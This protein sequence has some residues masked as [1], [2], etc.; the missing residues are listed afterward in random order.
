MASAIIKQM[1]RTSLYILFFLLTQNLS[2]K[3]LLTAQEQLWVKTH[4]LVYYAVHPHWLPFEGLDN[5]NQHIG[6]APEY[7]RIIA[8]KTG[9]KFELLKATSRQDALDL[10]LKHEVSLISGDLLNK[11]LKQ[12]FE[13]TF[14][15][16]ESA[17]VII[18]NNRHR[19]VENLYQIRDKKIVLVDGFAYS[20]RI[21]LKYPTIRFKTVKNIEQALA[22]VSQGLY[23]A[24]L[25]STPLASY[26]IAKNSY[27]NI[28]VVGKTKLVLRLGFFIEKRNQKLKEILNKVFL[29]ISEE[30]RNT[31]MQRWVTKHYI[32]KNNLD[33]VWILSAIFAFIIFAYFI[34]NRKLRLEIEKR[35]DAESQLR[36]SSYALK[37]TKESVEYALRKARVSQEIAE[38]A[39]ENAEIAKIQAELSWEQAE[40]A[41][42]EA[43]QANQAKSDFLA[44]MSH[45]IRTPMNAV[46]GMSNLAL[47][48]NLDET[49]RNYIKKVKQAGESLLGI[50]ND[51]LD[52][53]KIEAGKLE[54]EAIEFELVEVLENVANI[55]MFKVEEHKLELLFDVHAH[56]PFYLQGDPLRLGQIL[57]NLIN[58][59]VKFTPEGEIILEIRPIRQNE[60]KITLQFSIIDTGIGMTLEQQNKLFKA[61]NQ[62]DN[63][64]TRKYG[65]TGLGL[66][67]CKKLT[68]MMEGEIWVHSHRNK[69]S[70]FQ[71]T[72]QFSHSNKPK[73]HINID[74]PSFYNKNILIIDENKTTL[75][76]LSELLHESQIQTM[77]SQSLDNAITQLKQQNKQCDL[78]MLD[79][80]VIETKGKE[81]IDTL[82]QTMK[83]KEDA[84][85]VLLTAGSELKVISLLKRQRLNIKAFLAKPF[86]AISVADCLSKTLGNK[87]E[88]VEEIIFPEEQYSQNIEQVRGRKILLV[89]DNAL[90]TELAIA[91]LEQHG[92]TVKHAEHGQDA[93]DILAT[94]EV[95]DGI[96]MDIQM[97][98]L[99]GYET[100]KAIREQPKFKDLPIIAMTA[101]VMKTDIDKA[102]RSGMNGHIGKPIDVKSLFAS[103]AEHIGC[104]IP[105]HQAP[106]E[107]VEKKRM[108]VSN[109]T[110]S[111]YG[112]N[113]EQGLRVVMGDKPL[114][115][116]I[117]QRFYQD[118]VDFI[119]QF[120]ENLAK[121]NKDA[122]RIAHTLK[123]LAGTIG[124]QSLQSRAAFLEKACKDNE[125]SEIP[126]LLKVAVEEL[127]LVLAS[128]HK[129]FQV[130]LEPEKVK[131]SNQAIDKA[132]LSELI[133]E[134]KEHLKRNSFGSLK[135]S[136]ELS[137][138]LIGNEHQE[139]IDILTNKI[140]A[141]AFAD[142]LVALSALETALDLS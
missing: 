17:L 112:V 79:W 96:L 22:G 2:A 123:G 120:N 126:L 98:V 42:K 114:Y 105:V 7:L 75:K 5:Q 119:Q 66:V 125:E 97:P 70:T 77:V 21:K 71:F 88:Q 133:S 56:S 99:D 141:F 62:A 10:A 44:N 85:F 92:I 67:I 90:N 20:E 100:T 103:M 137:D 18:M 38:M 132:Q 19:Y 136:I 80:K 32:E 12:S 26:H 46:I 87:S 81:I 13:P 52:F 82:R 29:S 111:L 36:E 1:K 84:G 51:I 110:L 86:H 68:E 94:G 93:L 106:T 49:Q 102:I 130:E 37:R 25:A 73:K 55:V 127:E 9:L 69:G 64:T 45:E 14:P 118:Q 91:I 89:E 16:A 41:K 134:L 104:Q 131:S 117:I 122:M 139:L 15:Y 108:K 33:L 101:N 35:E 78:V 6:I 8:Q 121:S 24:C 109:K 40:L 129:N 116:K 128:I 76:I 59:A 63:S 135:A 60:N 140:K 95:F 113:I 27:H 57:T 28:K 31:L 83:L 4:P 142:S 43:E 58:N 124:A 34:W 72:A 3:A 47:Q 39:K 61:F 115:Y 11:Q 23:D 50:I 54:I 53:S 107:K 30:E 74:L 138:A 48:T 65:G